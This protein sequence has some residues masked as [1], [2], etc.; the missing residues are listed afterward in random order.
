MIA[1]D[2]PVDLAVRLPD[3]Q[4]PLC[5]KHI[6]TMFAVTLIPLIKT[7][8]KAA[9]A[10]AL[11]FVSAA[12]LCP[13]YYPKYYLYQG[14]IYS[15]DMFTISIVYSY[16]S[17][18]YLDWEKTYPR[19]YVVI[20]RLNEGISLSFYALFMAYW[21]YAACIQFMTHADN[22]VLIQVGN[23]YMSSAWYIYFSTSS[24]LYYFICIKLAQRAQSINDWLKNLKRTRPQIADFYASYKVH[25]KAI[26]VFGRN[27]NF[28]VFMGFIIL[29]YHIP[30]DL[31]NVIFNH[32][33]T[34]IVGV[35][36][37]SLSLSWYTYNIC[38]LNDVDSKVVPYLYKHSLYSTEEMAAIEKY[39][40][41]HELGLNFYGIKI[42]GALIVKGVLL[43]I[44]LIIPT[45]YALVSNQLI[46][47]R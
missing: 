11:L 4:L 27:W 23:V 15:I 22:N 35:V 36:I 6:T 9:P 16:L 44:N 3:Q 7:S 19:E 14:E 32:K 42:S 43:T 30:I 28:I 13:L 17:Y 38:K 37:K 47:N 26:K 5:E 31:L 33:Y 21:L 41:Y 20:S 29:T 18:I 8:Y 10:A 24:L 46:G 12:T 25:H 34:D 39:V 1:P 2:E 40:L 45:I